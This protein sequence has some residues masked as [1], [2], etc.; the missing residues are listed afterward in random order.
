MQAVG[1]MP[2]GA[3]VRADG[4]V[5]FHLWAPAAARVE[6]YL[7]EDAGEAI[8][9][10]H[11]EPGG[12]FGLIT[13][14]AAP[15]S[16]YR[17]RIDGGL[18]VPDPASRY[19]PED[20]HGPSQVIDPRSWRWTDAHWRGR[21]W[22]E[23]V[24]YELHVGAFTPQGTFAAVIDRLD[25]LVELGVTALELM[26]IADFHGARNW[27]YDGVLPFAPDS[28]YGRPEDLKQLIQSAHH[29]GLMVLLD[30]VYNHFGPEGNF[31]HHY[32]PAF[33]STRRHTPWGPA[34]NFD[35]PD[36]ETVRRFFI[37][38]AL[39]WLREYRFDGLRLDAVDTIRD[40][41]SPDLL[42]AIAAA[43][44]QGPGRKR[45]IHLILE[46]DR[47]QARYLLRDQDGRPRQYTAQWN[48]DLHHT[49]HL[50]L[51]G[52]ADGCHGDFREQPLHYLGRG[53]AQGFGYQ[54]EPSAYRGGAPRGE[55]SRNLPPTAFVAFLQNHDQ[56]GNRPFGER[57]HQ[58]TEPVPL[59]A[60]LALLLLAPTPP[61]LFMGEEFAAAQPFQF[62]CDFGL[63]LAAAVAAGR[64]RG[65]N[66]FEGF[67]G[68]LE[69]Q[70]PPDPNHPDTFTRCK[71]DW[72]SQDQVPHADWL[73]YYRELLA[74]RHRHIVPRLAGQPGGGADLWRIGEQGL[75]IRWPLGDGSR[76]TLL[77]NPSASSLPL[78]A[79]DRP[80]GEPLY[81]Y[82][83]GVTIDGTTGRLPAW[84]TAW[85]LREPPP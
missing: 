6:L 50:L 33:F 24:I 14:R 74:L 15:S 69:H 47:N 67:A 38:N 52:E 40:G 32:A 73:R 65:F 2:F 29:K 37:H 44:H 46:N 71:L 17:Y 62:F 56:V 41:S 35:G 26:P 83:P 84:C 53:L 77:V 61:L 43:V 42:E 66:C 39:H 27:G 4:Q 80:T 70:T 76:L 63:E 45:H 11:A 51:T 54:G 8:L 85:F 58:L 75:R 22:E 13:D 10:L 18:W 82:P 7:Q 60:A 23:A 28:R 48:D 64:R 55:P 79:A 16:R 59:R 19:Q 30:V 1:S 72:T 81:T 34:L 68:L 78:T 21:P 5:R 57:L 36:S 25:Y 49:L 3:E 12:W 9:P 31:L 20:V